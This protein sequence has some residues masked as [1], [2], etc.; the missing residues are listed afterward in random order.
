MPQ[1]REIP[2][3]IQRLAGELSEARPMRRGT[4]STRHMKCSKPTC[5]CA[6]D[7]DARHGPYFSLTRSVDGRTRS[8]YLSREQAAEARRQIEAGQRFRQQIEAFWQVCE[9]WAD[10]E[11]ER[12]PGRDEEEAEKGGSRR[13][14]RGKSRPRSRR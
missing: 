6:H 7:P 11:L 4:V 2:L 8:R 12:G 14:S 10:E 13:S 3:E 5:A 9:R 1:S